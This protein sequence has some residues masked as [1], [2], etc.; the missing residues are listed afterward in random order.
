MS[1]GVLVFQEINLKI[2]ELMEEIKNMKLKFLRHENRIRELERKLAEKEHT[3]QTNEAGDVAAETAVAKPASQ[4][5][6]DAG[7]RN[8]SLPA[9]PDLAPDEV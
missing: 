5:S 2:D 6:N 3:N 9:E 4:P 7:H 8:S 1:Y